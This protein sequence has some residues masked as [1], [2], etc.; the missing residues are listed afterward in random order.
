MVRMTASYS[1]SAD[2]GDH[3]HRVD[4]VI[5]RHLISRTSATRTRVQQWIATGRV[6]INGTP[7]ARASARTQFGDVVTIAVEDPGARTA[8]QPE[9][10]AVHVLYEDDDLL[11]IDKPAGVVAHPGYRHRAGTILNAL[12]WQAR[13]WPSPGRP[14]IVGRLDRQTS[15]VML[16]AKTSEMHAALQRAMASNA[17]EKNYLAVV[18]GRLKTR[19]VRIDLR[20]ERDAVDRRRVVA[21]VTRGAESLTYVERLDAVRAPSAGLALLRCRIATGRMH[22]IRVHLAARGWPIVG[23][24]VYGEP[25]WKLVAEPSLANVLRGFSRQALHAWRL[26]FDHPATGN[27][28]EIEAPLPAD[29]RGLMDAAGLTE[30]GGGSVTL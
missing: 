28:I 15:G 16:V 19:T 2:R 20:L 14:S 21:S 27:R 7:V 18:Y 26:S 1:I 4:L 9:R 6:A 29:L 3:G 12:L 8:P 13:E 30:T 23:D 22:Q 17:T 25:R 11:A 5:R 10:N 24:P